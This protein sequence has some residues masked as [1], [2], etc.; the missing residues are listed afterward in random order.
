VGREPEKDPDLR[1]IKEVVAGNRESFAGLVRKYQNRVFS[2][3]LRFLK[4]R[5]DAGD[6]AQEVFVKA[7]QRLGSF[8]GESLFSTWLMKVAYY[9]G[10]SVRRSW[11]RDASLPDDFDIPDTR[12]I[13]QRL[14][15]R[16]AAGEALQ[17][18]L[19]LLPERYR[20]CIDLYFSFG[21]RYDDISLITDIPAGT[22]K[23]HVFRAKQAL[24]AALKDSAAEDYGY[25]M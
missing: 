25:G 16:K 20:I 8:R 13:P 5:D 23:S 6:F 18:A 21:M 3:G 10:I 24:R 12:D 11:K 7:F 2:L 22:V 9:H 4:N 1:I 14:Y 15:A 19:K 17:E